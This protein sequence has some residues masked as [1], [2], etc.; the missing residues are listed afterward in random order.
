MEEWWY[1]IAQN[2]ANIFNWVILELNLLVIKNGM[3]FLWYYKKNL[4]KNSM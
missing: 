1:Q 3:K 4:S 2:I